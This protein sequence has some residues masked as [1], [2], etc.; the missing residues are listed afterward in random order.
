MSEKFINFLPQ[1]GRFAPH[2]IMC[3][4]NRNIRAIGLP[5]MSFFKV[6]HSKKYHII[7]WL[8]SYRG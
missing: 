1:K 3:F 5:P 4:G 6:P 2:I 7:L 8:V